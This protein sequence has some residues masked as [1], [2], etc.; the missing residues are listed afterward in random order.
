M[1]GASLLLL[2]QRIGLPQKRMYALLVGRKGEGRELFLRAFFPQLP[3][4]NYPY[5]KVAYVAVPYYDPFGVI[6]ACS[7]GEAEQRLAQMDEFRQFL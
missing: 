4:Q 5:V 7:W 1:T 6:G 2:V 3:A